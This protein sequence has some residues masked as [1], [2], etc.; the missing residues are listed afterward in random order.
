[1]KLV[2]KT[3]DLHAN[4]LTKERDRRGKKEGWE[5]VRAALIRLGGGFLDWSAI[6]SK[7]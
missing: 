3:S 2:G 1:M 4:M 6:L 5:R 7:L